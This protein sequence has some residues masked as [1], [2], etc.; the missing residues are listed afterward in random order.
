MNNTRSNFIPC[1]WSV[2]ALLVVYQARLGFLF[3]LRLSLRLSGEIVLYFLRPYSM[4]GSPESV[5]F[6]VKLPFAVKQPNKALWSKVSDKST[7]SN[8]L[9]CIKRVYK[10]ILRTHT[11]S[12]KLKKKTFPRRCQRVTQYTMLT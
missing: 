5:Y 11:H 4:T 2:Q 12:S 6:F 10:K 1:L 7:K 8:I 3:P 9:E